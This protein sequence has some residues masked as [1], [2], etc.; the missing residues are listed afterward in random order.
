MLEARGYVPNTRFNSLHGSRRLLFYDEEH[1]RQLDVIFDELRMSH[2]LNLVD[3]LSTHATTL[4][5]ADLLLTKLQIVEL[6][7]KDIADA[8]TLVHQHELAAE[9]NGDVL[10]VDRLESVTSRDWGWFT[11]VMDNLE[12]LAEA[13]PNLLDSD[14]LTA[15]DEKLAEIRRRL[16]EAPK[17]VRW[18]ARARV[19]R[20]V[21]WYELPEEV[22]SG[23]DV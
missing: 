23:A 4:S 19:G 21:V 17:S 5:P 2:T 3:R 8:L 7:R 6:N 18:K 14:D 10:G 20:H 9:R 1:G 13:A 16:E 22:G 11:T 12:R 15:V